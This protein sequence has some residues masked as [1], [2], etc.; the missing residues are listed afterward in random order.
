MRYSYKHRTGNSAATLVG[1]VKD[2]PIALF[3]YSNGTA[4]LRGG[5]I[6]YHVSWPRIL[7]DNSG[8]K[9]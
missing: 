7:R 1:M 4:F 5:L 3:V 2:L 9:K 8:Y 6:I